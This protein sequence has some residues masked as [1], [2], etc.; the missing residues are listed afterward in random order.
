MTIVLMMTLRFLSHD[1]YFPRRFK[2]WMVKIKTLSSIIR[3]INFYLALISCGVIP[4][5]LH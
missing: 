2:F 5:Y 1:T 4:M 3:C